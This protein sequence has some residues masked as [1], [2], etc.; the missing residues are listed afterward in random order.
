MGIFDVFFHFVQTNCL[1]DMWSHKGCQYRAS[2]GP[3]VFQKALGLD[4]PA[5]RV[6]QVPLSPKRGAGAGL[7]VGMLT[8]R[9]FPYL[10]KYV[11]CASSVE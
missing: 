4:I 2:G 7:G 10:K 9:G 3:T 8:G 11:E 5:T 1:R 6:P